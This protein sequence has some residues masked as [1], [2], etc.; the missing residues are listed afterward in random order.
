MLYTLHTEKTKAKS[1]TN[2]VSQMFQNF[3]SQVKTLNKIYA[4]ACH[5]HI[6]VFY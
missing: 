1:A 4:D 5:R 3:S 6:S 2:R